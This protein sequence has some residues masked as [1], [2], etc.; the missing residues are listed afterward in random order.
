[1]LIV[2]GR[3]C[4]RPGDSGQSCATALEPADDRVDRVHVGHVGHVLRYRVAG[5]AAEAVCSR[6][7]RRKSSCT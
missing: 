5:T 2:V 4:R 7:S 6:R 1:M 3:T